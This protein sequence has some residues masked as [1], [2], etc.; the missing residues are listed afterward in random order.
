Y[1]WLPTGVVIIALL[2]PAFLPSVLRWKEQAIARELR[3]VNAA[4]PLAAARR[5]AFERTISTR[6]GY[7]ISHNPSPLERSAEWQKRYAL[8]AKALA[9]A[10]VWLGPEARE[11][12]A[13]LDR[14][15]EAFRRS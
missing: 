14:D 3:E 6:A 8:A 11:Q 4:R 12:L 7:Q 13:R 1:V 9:S 5:A 15:D 10:A 2:A